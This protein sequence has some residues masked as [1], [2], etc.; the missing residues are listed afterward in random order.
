MSVSEMPTAGL[1]PPSGRS[2]GS[3]D[4]LDTLVRVTT[5]QAWV[6]LATLFTVSAA[7]VT[8]AIVYQ[9]QT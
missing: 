4:Q 5:I 7:A 9:V 1:D 6:Y 8:F 2:R 3:L